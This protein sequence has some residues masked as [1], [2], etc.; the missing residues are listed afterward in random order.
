[1]SESKAITENVSVE[2]DHGYKDIL[3]TYKGGGYDGCFWEWNFFIFDSNGQFIDIGSSG[4]KAITELSEA[5]E[6]MADE[7]NFKPEKSYERPEAFL[8]N[9]NDKESIK[10]F[11]D[12]SNE[13]HVLN[14]IERVNKHYLDALICEDKMSF[15]C[16]YCENQVT[17][18]YNTGYKGAGGI[19]IA[20]TGLICDDCYCNHTC[21]YCGEF[22]EK[23]EDMFKGPS[24]DKCIYCAE[25]E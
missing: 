16:P 18:G 6:L 11:V 20:W 4:Y 23:T 2:I 7:T 10:E 1:M 22:H 25:D 14:V 12:E 24:E 3:V 5:L 21:G 17:H 19:A 9:L 8:T 13:G 15:Q